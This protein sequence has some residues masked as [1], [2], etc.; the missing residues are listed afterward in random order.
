MMAE[1]RIHIDIRLGGNHWEANDAILVPPTYAEQ[2]FIPFIEHELEKAVVRLE[3]EEFGYSREADIIDQYDRRLNIIRL[4][5]HHAPHDL[6]NRP[7]FDKIRE[8]IDLDADQLFARFGRE[9]EED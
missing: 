7:I 9:S 8:V 2:D 4:M 5:L 3:R 1:L 6:R